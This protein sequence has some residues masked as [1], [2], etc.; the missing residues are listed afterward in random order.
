[1]VSAVLD[2]GF[3]LVYLAALFVLQP[4]FAAAALMIGLIQVTVMLATKRALREATERD[5][6][7]AAE[8]QTYL[9]EALG[10][11]AILKASGVEDRALEHWSS[12]FFRHLD[13]SVRKS[14]LSSIVGNV[15]VSLRIFGSLSLLWLAALRVLDNTMTLG[16]MFAVNALAAM[17]LTPLGHWWQSR[18]SCIWSAPISIVFRTFWQPS[19]NRL[20]IQRAHRCV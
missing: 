11:I 4:A 20:N 8:S 5:L 9:V 2:G 12:L 13:S 18:S 16:M 15:L 17:F 14:R 7:A 6:A 10:G 3:V 1:M 19:R